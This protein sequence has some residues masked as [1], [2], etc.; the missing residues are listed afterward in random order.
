MVLDS[1]KLNDICIRLTPV[2][3]TFYIVFFYFLFSFWN[4]TLSSS[5]SSFHIFSKYYDI[6]TCQTCTAF[7]E[8][9][10]HLLKSNFYFPFPGFTFFPLFLLLKRQCP[11]HNFKEKCI[12]CRIK[13]ITHK[14]TID[15]CFFFVTH[16]QLL[17]FLRINLF[18]LK[19]NFI[20]EKLLIQI[21]L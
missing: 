19:I 17:C 7:A 12:V 4:V 3:V 18:F 1:D 21:S 13:K 16:W 15:S 2:D 14:K 8:N 6:N 10:N 11:H 20:T 9:L 5:H